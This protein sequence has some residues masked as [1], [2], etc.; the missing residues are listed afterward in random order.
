MACKIMYVVVVLAAASLGRASDRGR[1]RH[2]SAG[3]AGTGAAAPR[4]IP[5]RSLVARLDLERYKATIKGLT[6]FGD[7]RHGTDRNR[8]AVDWIEAQLRAMAVRPNASSMTTSR[9]RATPP[10]ASAAGRG[11]GTQ[12]AGNKRPGQGGSTIFGTTAPHRREQRSGGA[13]RREAARAECAARDRRSSRR[14]LLHQGGL[15]DVP[16][17]MYIIG[18]H[19]DGIGWGEAANDDG[20]GTAIVMELARIFSSPD[21]Q[22]D[23]TIRFALWNNEETGL[24][25]ARAYV[26]AAPGAAGQGEPGRLGQVS[27]AEMAGHDSARHDDVRSRHAGPR[28]QGQPGA[29][30]RS[31]RQHRVPEQL[32]DGGRVAEARLAGQGGQRE[33]CHRL[34]GRGRV[35]T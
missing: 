17:E 29:A 2:H 28:R 6:Q 11:R 1:R 26:A 25:G 34:S 12:P 32:E 15:E 3:T 19:M 22:T 8:A 4:P 10:P 30:P 31:G 24:N 35:R 18:A 7:R 13:A 9:R 21:V 23:R 27:R 14:G 16:G 20:S 5:F 33:I